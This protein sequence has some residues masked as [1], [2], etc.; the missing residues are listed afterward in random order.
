VKDWSPAVRAAVIV[1]CVLVPR[2]AIAQ[3]LPPEGRRLASSGERGSISGVVTKRPS[4]EPAAGAVIRVLNEPTGGGLF[5]GGPQGALMPTTKAGADG[6]FLLTGVDPGTHWLVATLTGSLPVEYG[7]R[8]PT[9]VGMS[10]SVRAGQRMTVRLAL[11]PT[12]EISGRVVDADGDPVGRAQVLALRSIYEG[13]KPAITITQTVTTNDRGEYRMFWL[14]PGSYRVAARTF[15]GNGFIPAVNIGPPRRF[16]TSEQGTPPLVRRRTLDSGA[17]IEEVSIPIFAPSTPDPQLAS[18]I[19]L[20]PGENAVGVDVQ[21][22]GNRIPAHHVRGFVQSMAPGG[23]LP[24]NASVVVVPRARS[25]IGTVPSAPVRLDGSFDVAGVAAG[26]YIAYLRD[27]SAATPVEVGDGDVDNV[28]LAESAGIDISGRMTIERGTAATGSPDLPGLR[29][30]LTRDP[31]QVGTPSGASVYNPPPAPDG[32][33][34]WILYPGDYRLALLPLLNRQRD[35][36]TRSGGGPPVS[37]ALQNAY[38]KSIRL[39]RSDVLVDGLHVWGGT[40]GTLEIVVSLAGAEVEGTVRD[41]QGRQAAGVVVVAAPD[42]SIK[43][44]AD[45]YRHVTTDESAHFVLRGLAPGDYSFYAWDDLERG[46]WESVE[47]IR[48]FEG[49]GQFVRLREGKNDSIDLNLLVGR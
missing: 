34:M 43:G 17:A 4:G 22:A 3:E 40:Q 27:G 37:D 2:L 5:G 31:D 16:G 6:S 9:G 42:G 49:R 39:G 45:L 47:F 38:V 20:A 26:S 48:A 44:R 35:D 29:F 18:I 12:S 30:Q 28:V 21:L 41:L 7:Q 32:T 19:G 10:F 14:T 23:S 46:A 1:A 24:P 25:P 13:G 15:E 8:G 33:F 11:W 36:Q